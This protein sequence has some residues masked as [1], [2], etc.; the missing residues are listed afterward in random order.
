MLYTIVLVLLA[1]WLLGFTMSVGGG[2]VHLLLA[3][4]VVVLL[5][6]FLGGRRQIG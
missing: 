1:L 5:V 3:V 4:A 6:N 2:L